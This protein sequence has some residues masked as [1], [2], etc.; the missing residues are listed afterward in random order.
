M[1]KKFWKAATLPVVARAKRSAGSRLK[2]LG[3]SVE[4]GEILHRSGQVGEAQPGLPFCG[5]TQ[6]LQGKGY[7][8]GIDFGHVTKINHARALP[9]VFFRRPDQPRYGIKRHRAFE[10]ERVA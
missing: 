7:R 8:G 3:D 6:P 9:Q 5:P 2:Q 4:L 1:M 10:D